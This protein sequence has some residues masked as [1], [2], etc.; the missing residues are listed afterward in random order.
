MERVPKDD[1]H[2][3]V[4]KERYVQ[5]NIRVFDLRFACVPTPSDQPMPFP[6]KILRFGGSRRQANAECHCKD[7]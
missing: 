4:I 1:D 7:C 5:L 2:D 3:F 6:I